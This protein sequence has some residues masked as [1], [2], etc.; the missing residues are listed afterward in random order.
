MSFFSKHFLRLPAG[1]KVTGLGRWFQILEE[2]FMVLFKVNLVTVMCLFPAVFS[3]FVMWKT[4]DLCCGL[5][6]IML[7][8]CAGPAVTALNFIC[9][10]KVLDIP[11]WLTEDYK[12]CVRK[13]WKYSM[14]LS[15]IVSVFWSAFFYAVYIVVTVE[16]GLPFFMLLLFFVYGYLLTGFTILAYQQLSIVEL[17]FIYILKNAVLLI[18]AGKWRSFF[19]ILFIEACAFLSVV[20]P[21][22]GCVL[23]S[24]GSMS[25]CIMT[26]DLI[27]Q[28]EFEKYFYILLET[29]HESE[30]ITGKAN[31]K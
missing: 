29:E 5:L 13:R 21:F 12:E 22:W 15:A 14:I 3:F 2:S 9:M 7:F 19:M 10:K 17:R 18:F 23:L 1:E 4:G 28:P 24:A 27:F 8:I 30:E 11:V 20:F 26:G 6:G 31:E 16:K 25:V